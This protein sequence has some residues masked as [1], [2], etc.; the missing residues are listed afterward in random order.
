MLG[1]IAIAAPPENR[2]VFN[3]IVKPG[4]ADLRRRQL[5]A[6]AMVLKRANEGERAGDI[7]IGDDQ[8]S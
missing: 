8:R 6:R 4:L 2:A 5:G 1:R 3:D 7:V